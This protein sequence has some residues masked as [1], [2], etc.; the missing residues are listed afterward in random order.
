MVGRKK[1][2]QS[3]WPSSVCISCPVKVYLQPATYFRIQFQMKMWIFQV[4]TLT[5][6]FANLLPTSVHTPSFLNLHDVEADKTF[7]STWSFSW[8]IVCNVDIVK[9]L[10]IRHEY[11]TTITISIYRHIYFASP[12]RTLKKSQLWGFYPLRRTRGR[13][14]YIASKVSSKWDFVI[15]CLSK[16]IIKIR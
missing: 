2:R 5:I 8:F 1:G 9:I 12:G 7:L 16:N 10:N 13:K 3:S 4:P 14:Q 15:F 6:I 11:A